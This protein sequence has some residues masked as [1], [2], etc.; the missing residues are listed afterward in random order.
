MRVTA[1]VVRVLATVAYR[2]HS[3]RKIVTFKPK[4]GATSPARYVAV[5]LTTL[6]LVLFAGGCLWVFVGLTLLN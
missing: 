1:K 6:L 2:L 5:Y 4:L 3:K